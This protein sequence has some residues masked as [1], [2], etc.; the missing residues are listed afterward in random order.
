MLRK[1][2]GAFSRDIAIDLGT[3]NIL[4]YLRG[5]GIVLNEPSVIAMTDIRGRPHVLAVGAEAKRMVG[6]TPGNIRA[7][8]PLKGGVI[9]DFEIAQHMI[10]YMIRRVHQR[11][12]FFAPRVIISV[13]SGSTPV[14]RRAI[15]EAAE[16]AGA[17]EVYLIEEP[18]AAAIGAGLPVMEPTGSLI[19]DIGGGTTEVAVISLGGIV[20]SHSVRVAGDAMDEHIVAYMRRAH[21]IMIGEATAEKI[22][23]ELGA[24]ATSSQG[25]ETV[26]VIRGRDLITGVPREHALGER[27]L[28]QCLAEQV[29]VIVEVVMTALER[30]P[31]ELAADV[32]DRGIV[33]AGGGALLRHLDFVLHEATGLRV[34]VAED[35]LTCV[36]RGAGA[37]LENMAMLKVAQRQ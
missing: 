31:P 35:A 17:R 32:V 23:I 18:M 5:S 4:V 3:A 7:I 20:S 26:T 34:T 11:R 37:T 14:E 10:G 13:P 19:V 16:A 24:A 36:A 33:L 30:M 8:R 21:N 9:A 27:E 15:Y 28:A 1:A 2:F 22:K 29:G 25:E 6:R 12:G